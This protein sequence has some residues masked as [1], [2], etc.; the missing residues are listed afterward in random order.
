LFNKID[1]DDSSG[2][3]K[4][5]SFRIWQKGMLFWDNG[6]Y[7]FINCHAEYNSQDV[8]TYGTLKKHM[9]KFL[10]ILK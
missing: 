7:Q 3:E 4:F 1:E 2:W 8:L 10:R 6:Y 9:G 5:L